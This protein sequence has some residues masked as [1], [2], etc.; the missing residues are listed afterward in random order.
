MSGT[1]SRALDWESTGLGAPLPLCS[2]FL[3]QFCVCLPCLRLLMAPPDHHKNSKSL[4]AG[5][6]QSGPWLSS[7]G[8]LTCPFHHTS[9][10]DP[11]AVPCTN[12]DCH[13][14]RTFALAMIRTT[15]NLCPWILLSFTSP[16]KPLLRS[17]PWS[18][19]W[20][21][22]LYSLSHHTIFF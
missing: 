17:L 12:Q 2:Q 5:K 7:Q 13:H 15:W 6:L 9:H 3:Y 21:P 20:V 16:S 8:S 14:P 1:I 4:L 11:L 19:N 18:C 22:S 10:L